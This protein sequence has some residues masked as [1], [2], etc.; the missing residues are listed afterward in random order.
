MP[1]S[2]DKKAQAAV[3]KAVKAAQGSAA[4]LDRSV[5]NF[6][7]KLDELSTAIAKHEQA[8]SKK[9][10]EALLSAVGTCNGLQSIVLTQ[11]KQL[12]RELKA[13]K[14]AVEAKDG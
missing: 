7:D 10:T 8:A 12:S 9:T 14:E 13:V 3:D 1:P 4:P 6:A 11:L 2:Q 5:G